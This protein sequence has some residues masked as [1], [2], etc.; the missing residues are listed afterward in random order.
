M[1]RTLGLALLAL[2]SAVGQSQ[3]S[4]FTGEG[5]GLSVGDAGGARGP[6]GA[7]PRAR[8]P[9]MCLLGETGS[10]PSWLNFLVTT[11]TW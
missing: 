1:L 11:E 4:G 8:Q 7:E 10:L 5:S 2:V 9:K 6:L 3:A